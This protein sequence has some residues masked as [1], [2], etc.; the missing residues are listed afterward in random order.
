MTQIQTAAVPTPGPL[1]AP[2]RRTWLIA[3]GAAG[4]AALVATAVPFVSSMAPSERARALGAAVEVD[5]SNLPPG[6]MKT[7]EWRGKPVWILRRTPENTAAELLP[8]PPA[9][10]PSRILDCLGAMHPSGLRDFRAQGCVADGSRS[11]LAEWL[12]LS[13]PRIEVRFC[14]A[15]VQERA[16]AA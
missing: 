15:G 2:E 7:V 13:A 9:I 16:G 5:L 4:S 6:G 11:G 8:R 10:D 14:R 3:S 1:A 12:L